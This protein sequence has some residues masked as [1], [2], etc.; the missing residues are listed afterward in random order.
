MAKQSRLDE[1]LVRR[2]QLKVLEERQI[3]LQVKPEGVTT[4]V[5]PIAPAEEE[6]VDVENDDGDIENDSSVDKQLSNMMIG[7]VSAG[8]TLQ[9]PLSREVLNS[10]TK[11]IQALRL[12]YA[13]ISKLGKDLHCYSRGCN[14]NSHLISSCYSPMCLQR[15]KVRRELLGLLRKANAHTNMTK[16]PSILAAVVKKTNSEQKLSTPPAV[17]EKPSD[18]SICKDLEN[19]IAEA[20]K[21]AQEADNVYVPSKMTKTEVK[22]EPMEQM[23][24]EEVPKVDLPPVKKMKTEGPFDAEG[25][26]PDAIKEM[27]LGMDSIFFCIKQNHYFIIFIY[28]TTAAFTLSR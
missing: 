1:L 24:V 3:A 25:M 18:A 6:N 15:N 10:I 12:H 22:E 16:V 26:T 7:K 5:Q 21:C 13:S 27:I 4:T 9:T 28:N 19:V 14:R 17:K 8:S 2:T 23:E 20:P 11:R